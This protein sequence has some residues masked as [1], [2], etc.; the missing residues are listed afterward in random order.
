[1]NPV[2]EA[3][4]NVLTWIGMIFG[5]VGVLSF[6]IWATNWLGLL[7]RRAGRAASPDLNTVRR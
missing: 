2:V 4:M 6:V 1:M 5:G 3:L 7:G